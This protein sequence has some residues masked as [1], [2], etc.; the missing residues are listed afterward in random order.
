M[1]VRL[2]EKEYKKL[3]KD[4]KDLKED[5]S[6]EKKKKINKYRNTKITVDGLKFDSTKEYER[7][8]LLK[9]LEKSNEISNLRLH[10]K[11]DIIILID[12][13][14]V[15]YVPDFCYEENGKNIVEDFKGMQTKEFILKKK[16][17]ISMIK[18]EKLNITFRITKFVNGSFVVVE[19]YSKDNMKK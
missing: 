4:K 2:S 14:L 5:K 16:I 10:D 9:I 18:K 12:D 7:Y 17:I 11:K 6:T 1:A 13:P 3:V 15:K 19:E 8:S